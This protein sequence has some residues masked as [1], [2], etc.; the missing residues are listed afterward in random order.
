MSVSGHG[1]GCYKVKC[2]TTACR[3]CNSK[4]FYYECN[5]GSKVFFDALGGSWPNHH[6]GSAAKP[7]TLFKMPK[8]PSVP[9][10]RRT[11]AR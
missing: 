1:Y 4:V 7:A 9:R 8:V 3:T 11:Y 6:C 10:V 5:H 2:Y